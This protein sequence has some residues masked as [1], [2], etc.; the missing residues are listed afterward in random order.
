MDTI[1]KTA[2]VPFSQ[3][4]ITST[5]WKKA[6]LTPALTGLIEG[7]G[8]AS[9]DEFRG[10]M[11]GKAQMNEYGAICYTEKRGAF[12]LNY[13]DNCKNKFGVGGNKNGHFVDFRF[14]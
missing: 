13:S 4:G 12:E 14:N 5:P 7:L 2:K 1:T 6:G 10:Y 9:V 3:L 8:F 11:K